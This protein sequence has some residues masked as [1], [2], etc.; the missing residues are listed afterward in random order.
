MAPA[1]LTRR[2]R[3][4][5]LDAYDSFSN[6]IIAQ[7]EQC[8][9]AEIVKC[10]IDSDPDSWIVP[11]AAKARAATPAAFVEYAKT[12]D[13]VIAGPGPGSAACD[14]DV[15][16]MKV[17]WK[18]QDEDI[19]PVLSICLGFQ[20]MCLAFGAS[21]QKLTEPR[22]GI[23]SEIL[24]N[25][26]SIFNGTKQ[27]HATQ[28]HSLQVMLHHRIQTKKAVRY[29]AELWEPT[30]T[31]PDL[32][33]LAWD[34]GN[35][36][37]GAV[38]MAAR[39]INKPFWG[40]QFH[41]ESIC[42]NDEGM[43]IIQNW[44]AEASLESRTRN[45]KTPSSTEIEQDIAE[46]AAPW[47]K[48]SLIE[49]LTMRLVHG[50]AIPSSRATV[51]DVQCATTGSGR[52]TV[53]DLV[54][55]FDSPC[56]E[57]IVLESGLHRDLRP[58]ATDTG[59]HSIIGLVAPG[60]T[61]RL[62]YYTNT[63]V[64][65]LR[66]G[67]DEV[68]QKWHTQAP[69]QCIRGVMSHLKGMLGQKPQTSTWSPFWGGFMGYASYEAGLETIDIKS[70]EEAEYPD[71]CF[72][73]ITRSIVV[74]H[75]LKKIYIQSIRSTDDRSWVN[76]T[77]DQLY[78]AV[79]R[80]SLE[81][82][83]NPTPLPRPNPFEQHDT[84]LSNYLASCTRSVID[85]D[86]YCAS[87]G[88]CQKHIADGQSYEL[89]LTTTNKIRARRPR[90][91]R[92]SRTE[93]NEL[94]WKLYKRLT[95][96]NTAPFSAYMRLHNM[97]V[98]SSSPER[99][100]S[101]N[102]QQ[103]AQCRPIKGTVSKSSGA[104]ATDAHAIL[105][106]PKERAENLMIVDLV[107]HQLH[108]VYGAGNV[109]VSQLMQ[110]EEYETVWQLVSVVEGSPSSSISPRLQ[111][112][113]D[114]WVDNKDPA[115]ASTLQNQDKEEMLGFDA[116]TQSLPAGSMTG[117]PKKRSCELLRGLENGE[118]RGIYSGVLG[119][120]DIGGGGDFSVVIRTAVKIDAPNPASAVEDV[121]SIGA[122]GAI[123]TL[124]NP[125][126]EYDEMLAKFSS[127]AAAFEENG[128]IEEVEKETDLRGIWSRLM[129][130]EEPE[131]GE[132]GGLPAAPLLLRTLQDF[133]AGLLAG[134]VRTTNGVIRGRE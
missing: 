52:L 128:E 46:D 124:S 17:L 82:T 20:S 14:E 5:Y 74:D 43:R 21:I 116:F 55:L 93:D 59:R 31:C 86:Q 80:K 13:A 44:W 49:A 63:Q 130:V 35:R 125:Q 65:E 77:L 100:I 105:S 111:T 117:A 67:N 40:V 57:T 36:Q 104:T 19:V 73:Y 41:P 96:R 16:W 29:P 115:A 48:D 134:V 84:T 85:R 56:G 122:G 95:A 22:H 97:H 11:E 6:N 10:Y 108:G 75:Q 113:D 110:V 27:L 32:Q 26:T 50:D 120:L 66:D 69:W 2:P 98:L 89:C 78:D 39:H 107:R 18:L 112:S 99:Y 28:Y 88:S 30:E 33:P 38:L 34:F 9:D 129:E 133:Q 91:C 103:A 81:S 123:T 47:P 87:V 60:E 101:W 1:L 64:M 51:L 53:S 68:L 4:L 72:A 92:L 79:G 61:M 71:I 37:N 3:I 8:I 23:V 114:S 127:T 24:N 45:L 90:I 119:Y 118:R 7:V 58:M 12:F 70:K 126:S 25:G 42:T 121:W 102:R 54:E 132:D 15:G 62:H 94:S 83:P 106:T 131:D 76:E 109:H